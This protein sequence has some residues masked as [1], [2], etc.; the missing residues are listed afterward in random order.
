MKGFVQILIFTFPLSLLSVTL[1]GFEFYP[2]FLMMPLGIMELTLRAKERRPSLALSIRIGVGLFAL[3][4]LIQ[5][6]GKLFVAKDLLKLAFFIFLY[7]SLLFAKNRMKIDVERIINY[8]ILILVLGG[9]VQIALALSGR[10]DLAQAFHLMLHPDSYGGV[11]SRGFGFIDT[12]R[13]ASLTLEPSYFAFT[14]S[15]FI[16]LTNQNWVRF[17][18]AVGI[19]ISCSLITIYG[20]L[21]ILIYFVVRRLTISSYFFYIG[22]LGFHF[23]FIKTIY[24]IVPEQF[25]PT[26]LDR[27]AGLVE[28]YKSFDWFQILFGS[29]HVDE[30]WAVNLVRP[31]R[32]RTI[33]CSA[34]EWPIPI[35]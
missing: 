21:G 10:R 28:V 34:K 23:W 5:A 8:S 22:S 14:S 12:F 15:I 11:D 13:V 17:L 2:G 16:L 20:W 30:T 26:F 6:T 27:Y 1:G 31:P 9:I 19:F 35:M 7:Q 25:F 4:I 18:C 3:M 32:T 33:E 24:D 29:M